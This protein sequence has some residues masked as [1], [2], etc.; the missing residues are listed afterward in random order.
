MGGGCLRRSCQP[1]SICCPPRPPH[2]HLLLNNCALR[3][4]PW[5]VT[6]EERNPCSCIV[7]SNTT[8]VVVIER[9]FGRGGGGGG[10]GGT[11]SGPGV[12]DVR[13]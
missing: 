3:L 4:P 8:G 11:R 12:A 10:G 9:V 6:L 13:S 5:F 7:M 2:C 1:L